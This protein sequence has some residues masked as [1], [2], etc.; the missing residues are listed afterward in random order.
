MMPTA[1]LSRFRRG[2]A[3]LAALTLTAP[4]LADTS[5]RGGESFARWLDGFKQEAA[6]QGIHRQVL[7]LLDGVTLDP[8]VLKNDRGQPS[9]S[10]S[11]VQFADRL[12]SADRLN[13]GRALL[14]R[15]AGTFARTERDFGV[16]GPVIAAFWGLETDYGGYMGEYQ[17]LRSLTTLA[18]DCR[19]AAHF[20]AELLDAL[21]IVARGDLRPEEM[22]GAWAGELGQVQFTPSNYLSYAVDYD[23][24]GRRDL[25]GSVPDALASAAKLIRSLGWAPGE[26]WLEEV[27]ITA[28]TPLDQSARA[29]R[30]PRGF[31]A[32]S[33]VSRGDGSPLPADRMPAALILPMGRSGPAFLAYRNFDIYWEWNQSSNYSLTA[34]YFATRLAGAPPL[35]RGQPGPMLSAAE[36]KELQTRLNAAGFDAGTPD[37][38]LGEATRNGVRAAQLRLGMPADGFPTPDLL[39]RLRAG[40]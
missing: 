28:A 5:C 20:R 27:R 23:G 22:R 14:A 17:A 25:V 24:D 30:H 9:L 8:R 38:R 11:F 7:A 29:V 6:G 35:R 2:I 10:Q 19:R 36:L 26:P 34:A 4:A 15:H 40:L 31:W 1:R 16:P 3:A 18:Y 12:I 33:G 39:Q 32:R 13:R 37:G 21:R